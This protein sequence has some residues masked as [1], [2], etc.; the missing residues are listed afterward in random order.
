M[1]PRDQSGGVGSRVKASGSGALQAL[2]EERATHSHPSAERGGRD[3][4][5]LTPNPWLQCSPTAPGLG[6]PFPVLA[7]GSLHV[8]PSA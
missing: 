1:G 3:Q 7:G 8:Y 2:G 6:R 4:G 5:C